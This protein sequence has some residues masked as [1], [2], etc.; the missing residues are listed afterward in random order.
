MKFQSSVTNILKTIAK[1]MLKINIRNRGVRLLAPVGQ[2]GLVLAEIMLLCL[3]ATS[4]EEFTSPGFLDSSKTRSEKMIEAFTADHDPVLKTKLDLIN[5]ELR[6]CDDETSQLSGLRRSLQSADALQMVE[7]QIELIQERKKRFEAIRSQINGEIEK[8]IVHHRSSA[9]T[10]AGLAEAETRQLLSKA[11]EL[12]HDSEALALQVSDEVNADKPSDYAA[13]KLTMDRNTTAQVGPHA[14]PPANAPGLQAVP[15]NRMARSFI[16]AYIEAINR[17]ERP[18]L[19]RPL[20]APDLRY[21]YAGK[22]SVS[23]DNAVEAFIDL[24][25]RWD[26]RSFKLVNQQVYRGQENAK[27]YYDGDLVV[28]LSLDFEHREEEQWSSGRSVHR[29]HLKKWGA[30]YVIDNWSECITARVD[31]PGRRNQ[32]SL[33]PVFG[34]ISGFRL[35]AKIHSSPSS[36][37]QV[38]AKVTPGE[39]FRTVPS[40]LPWWRVET[41]E[42]KRGY[43]PN[44]IITT[45]R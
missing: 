8:A 17:P 20:L 30:A 24:A 6:K 3:G 31:S 28:I 23:R 32:L 11:S 36:D 34:K 5:V 35:P 33:T 42:G 16:K 13:S 14:K 25:T 1:K 7:G 12:I 27:D 4:C 21:S 22:E 43:L 37:S 10:G 44:K 9:A 38:V 15:M 19:L 2:R 45:G 18:S 41:K 29:L 39:V 40:S 26:P